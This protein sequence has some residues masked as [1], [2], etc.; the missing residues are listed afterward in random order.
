ML[1]LTNFFETLNEFAPIELSYRLIEKGD[2]DNS[3]ILVKN[4]EQ[5]SKVLFSLDLSEKALL[6]AKKLKCDTIVTHHP[7]IYAP[8]KNLN[9][10]TAG[11][12]EIITA[13]KLNLNV[14]SMHLNLDI[15]TGGI[16]ACLCQ[17]LGGEK[18]RVL[19]CLDEFNGYGREFDIPNITLEA[20]VKNL[21]KE[22][23]TSKVIVYGKRKNILKYGASFCGAGA[24]YAEKFVN[25]N[26][27]NAQV[28]VTSDIPHHALKTLVEKGKC[29]VV[30]THYSSE[31]YGF[32]KYYEKVQKTLKNKAEIYYFE[33]KRFL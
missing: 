15:A 27:T 3:G 33:D 22:L 20:F 14:I 1:K 13:V 28:I 12:N 7:A 2:Y 23:K 32:K 18:F 26:K 29:V 17:A 31:N 8:L 10:D 6:Q 16:D 4:H 5:I 25:E 30:L 19:D 11:G 21:K 9:V 24:S